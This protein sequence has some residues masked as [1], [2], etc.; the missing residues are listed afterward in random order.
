MRIP[1][2]QPKSASPDQI[3]STA[4][5]LAKEAKR[6]AA[7]FDALVRGTEVRKPASLAS[8]LLPAFLRNSPAAPRVPTQLP[9]LQFHAATGALSVP[10]HASN[11]EKSLASLAK[12]LTSEVLTPRES[13]MFAI[14]SARLGQVLGLRAA[15]SALDPSTAQH[16]EA[17]LLRPIEQL[18]QQVRAVAPRPTSAPSQPVT[19]TIEAVDTPTLADGVCAGNVE[20]RGVVTL[21]NKAALHCD[22]GFGYYNHNEDAAALLTDQRGRIFAGVFDQAGGMGRA[23]LGGGSK[24]AANAFFA[25][26]KENAV[27]KG[28]LDGATA[29]LK[30]ASVDAHEELLLRGHREVTT[31]TGLVID[32]PTARF[33]NT[34]DSGALWFAKGGTP[35][36][37]TRTHNMA[38]PMEHILTEC[39]G[40]DRNPACEVTEWQLQAGDWIV[41]GSDGLLDSKID[42]REM[43]A[44][45]AR[46]QS[47]E[48]ATEALRDLVHA[49]MAS[50]EGKPDNLSII[51]LHA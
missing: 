2:S 6:S 47:P 11:V 32:G 41:L 3:A 1:P 37:A 36:G 39:L 38:P 28:N 8:K 26:L 14:V 12:L 19:R 51:V 16:L 5:S 49:R 30:Q 33:V 46:S 44:I 34:G 9:A 48:E 23:D 18:L 27:A 25:R 42:P 13:R 35:K 17:Q 29:A 45:L 43:G 21:G 31:F 4:V 7:T 24:V 15:L 22:R 40:A 20:T 10:L 50:G